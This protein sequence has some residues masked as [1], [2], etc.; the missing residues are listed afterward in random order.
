MK[1]YMALMLLGML[2]IILL[3]TNNSK[4]DEGAYH[5]YEEMRAELENIESLHPNIAKVFNL[6][7]EY[8]VNLTWQNRTV[9]AIKIS[10]NVEE[11]EG[12]PEVLYMGA[13][14]AREWISVEV[15]MYFL[16]YLVD[17]YGKD[18]KVT[19]LV[20]N[21]Q[22]WIVPMLN[23]DGV[24]YSQT[25]YKMWRKNLRDNDG[26]GNFGEY[27][28]G[29]D[30]NRNY[31]FKWGG[32]GSSHNPASNIYCGPYDDK[33]DDNDGQ[34]NED[35][36]DMKDNDGDGKIDEDPNGGFSEPE[37]QAIKALVENHNFVLSLSYH[38]YGE[39]WI[40]P[41]GYTMEPTKD[42]DL[43]ISIGKNCTEMN[44]YDLIQGPE[45]YKTSGTSDDWLYGVHGI[46]AFTPELGKQFIPPEE[47]I[48]DI[49]IENLGPNLYIAEVADNPRQNSPKILH[50]CYNETTEYKKPYNLTAKITSE[51]GLNESSLK[52]HYRIND[53]DWVEKIMKLGKKDDE[54]YAKIPAQPT[55]TEIYYYIEAKDLNGN[56]STNPKYAPYSTNKFRVSKVKYFFDNVTEDNW[57]HEGTK[58][59]W[60]LTSANYFSKKYC[61]WNGNFTTSKYEDNT[62]DS[63]ITP[64]INLTDAKTAYLAFRHYYNF[65]YKRGKANDGG[66]VEATKDNGKTWNQIFPI[67]GYPVMFSENNPL[68]KI[69]GYGGKNN[70]WKK[71]LFDLKDYVGKIIKIR[72]HFASDSS[73]TSLGWFIDD[74]SVFGDSIYG[75]NLSCQNNESTVDRG[76]PVKYEIIVENEG[77]VKDTINIEVSKPPDEWEAEVEGEKL[78][79]N[80]VTLNSGESTQI[81]LTVFAPYFGTA[82]DFAVIKVTARSKGNLNVNDT[83]TTITKILEVYEILLESEN[84]SK[85]V[86]LWENVTY[87]I[88]IKNNGTVE[89]TINL[90][91]SI[92]SFGWSA[93]IKIDNLI[94]N[95]VKLAPYESKEIDFIISPPN[96]AYA[97][98]S[99]KIL[100]I[101]KSS[102]K[103][104]VSVSL[105]I[106]TTVKE[107][108]GVKLNCDEKIKYILPGKSA[109]YSL[110]IKNLGNLKDIFEIEASLLPK[111][112][113]IKLN[114]EN[115]SDSNISLEAFELKI[116]IITIF[117][118]N[119][120]LPSEIDT[121]ILVKSKYSSKISDSVNFTTIVI[122]KHDFEL[123]AH[124]PIH[125]NPGKEAIFSID[126][127]NN[128]NVKEEIEL[129]VNSSTKLPLNWNVKFEN[130]LKNY[131]INILEFDKKTVLLIVSTNENATTDTEVVIN[132][133]AKSENYS[134]SISLKIIINQVY[135]V[136]LSCKY[137]KK[138][139][140]PG[141]VASYTILV[142]NLGNG[143]DTIFISTSKSKKGWGIKF[144]FE[145][146]KIEIK[147]TAKQSET[148]TLNVLTP[149]SDIYEMDSSITVIGETFNGLF[150]N[151]TIITKVN[152]I[153][154]VKLVI[155]EPNKKTELEKKVKYAIKVTNNGNCKSKIFFE[156]TGVPKGWGAE[157]DLTEIELEKGEFID[158]FLEIFAPKEGKNGD[159]AVI[160]IIASTKEKSW[161]VE[162]TT[163]LV[164][165]ENKEEFNFLIPLVFLILIC[166]FIPSIFILKGRGK[167][168][169]SFYRESAK[170]EKEIIGDDE[171]EEWILKEPKEKISKEKENYVE[172]EQTQDLEIEK[173]KLIHDYL[174]QKEV[175]K[176]KGIEK[177]QKKKCP[178]CGRTIFIT[179]E[180][181]DRKKCIWCGTIVKLD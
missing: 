19:W 40:Y 149:E 91:N 181:K 80:S 113:E 108:Y 67:D 15:P 151:I 8:C 72:F 81:N 33:D 30:L 153:Y 174:V 53:L 121:D 42:H 35:P 13:H 122:E 176:S 77:D 130:G 111:N 143:E 157:L 106:N 31:A 84:T 160:T 152:I 129:T 135:G 25:S 60:N 158:I 94:V 58:N 9:W 162:T 97:N 79:D 55:G 142:Q 63:L 48:E 100:F 41:W 4:G 89:D 74:V 17:N 120:A 132:I 88:T 18:P 1:K 117:S 21:R 85:K 148:I 103:P 69:S 32:S 167:N 86:K 93:E 52:L 169:I 71:E 155:L 127:I 3:L 147:L 178:V 166:V 36:V 65:Y 156:Y 46:L 98:Y 144:N 109:I 141:E 62:N 159:K 133:D 73:D 96:N 125:V 115:L 145:S 66:I 29:V 7:A 37:T 49:C 134:T 2:I 26:D 78:N 68:G 5:S 164:K 95:S 47:Q 131:L 114:G 99:E 180:D 101:A 154:D 75:I 45:L 105:L 112:W 43:F 57:M 179:H 119:M 64:S 27:G 59:L 107:T 173:K 116:I 110:E 34:L 14:H 23:P 177:I 20:D 168:E 39:L 140:A 82:K 90:E 165:K 172:W 12:E 56:L 70:R 92:P 38:S 11:E 123:F 6:S 44:G 83:I 124:S 161:S 170:A 128:G 104:K 61:W 28:D 126:I 175:I 87:K 24:T 50:N 139:V 146:S 22:I 102:S 54:Y 136:E 137:N 150:S 16:N 138:E 118:Y 163:T 76:K 10:D 171:L 51:I